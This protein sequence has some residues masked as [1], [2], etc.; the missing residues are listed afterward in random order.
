M[1]LLL[2]STLLTFVLACAK[3]GEQGA[4]NKAAETPVVTTE[5]AV[6]SDDL[7]PGNNASALLHFRSG[8]TYRNVSGY[9]VG[10]EA[11]LN[12]D[13]NSRVY[14]FQNVVPGIYDIVVMGEDDSGNI[15]G[16]RVNGVLFTSERN[17]VLRD[18]AL[19]PVRELQGK[20]S[21]EDG[22]PAAGVIVSIVG[23]SISET[24]AA[25]GSYSLTGV[26]AGIHDIE[27]KEDDKRVGFINLLTVDKETPT[28]L[29][30]IVALAPREEQLSLIGEANS[31]NLRF[32]LTPP[33]GTNQYRIS[34]SPNFENAPWLSL[35]S[36]ISFE[37]GE[38]GEQ[39]LYTQFSVN[40]SQL[41]EVFRVDVEI[42]LP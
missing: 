15:L 12:F 19:S 26:P 10:H 5:N 30:E 17:A 25:D 23:T 4:E 41:S 11:R 40:G 1:K 28:S 13:E 33:Q 27:F 2:A 20:L 36:N 24:S 8:V 21:D 32:A 16:K 29:P 42:I 9:L 31:L 37:F 39:T 18:V 22:D 34:Q 14:R 3:S 38:A 6:G 7:L 35:I